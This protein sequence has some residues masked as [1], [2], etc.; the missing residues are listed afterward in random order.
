MIF[1]SVLFLCLFLPVT[2][3]LYHVLPARWKNALLLLASLAFYAFGEPV[4]V[5]L[6]VFSILLN[7]TGARLLEGCAG[8]G[9]RKAVLAGCVALNVGLLCLFKYGDLLIETANALTGGDIAPLRLALPVGISFYTFQAL[10]Y[11]IDVYRGEARARRNVCSFGLYICLFPQLIAGPIV[12]YPELADQ[13]DARTADADGFWSGTVRFCAGLAKK[14]IV[15]NQIGLLWE[16]I[17]AQA[18]PTAAAAWLGAAAYALQIYYDFSGYSDMAVG[19]GRLFG[20]RLPENFRYP[21]EA[22]SVTDFWRRWHI[23]LTRWLR[24][25]VYIPLGGNRCSKLRNYANI[26]VT[27]LVSG[28]WHGASWNFLLWG[29]YHGLLLVGE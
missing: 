12:R 20:F 22:D 1:G 11:V 24:D 7:Y 17:S 29:G 25:Q 6:M 8:R 15:A 16:E 9:G 13:L 2:L 26:L 3:G 10:S 4:Y 21:Y 27:F 14:V 19:L 23:S 5:L 18:A 28:L